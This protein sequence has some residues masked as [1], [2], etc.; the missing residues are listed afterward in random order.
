L[1]LAVSLL[2]ICFIVGF[3]IGFGGSAISQGITNGWDN[4]NWWQAGFDGLIGGITGLIGGSGIGVIG[5]MVAGEVLGFTGSVGSDLISNA[6]DFGQI[7]WG[8]AA[9]M[10]ALG[11]LTG[12]LAGAGNIKVMND[13]VNTGSSWGLSHF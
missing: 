2:V 13:A 11:I 7:N 3:V 1:E 12:F 8:K 9:I 4:V 6:G 10:G 5:S